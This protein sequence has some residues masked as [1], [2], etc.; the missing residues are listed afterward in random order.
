MVWVLGDLKLITG[1]FMG[2]WVQLMSVGPPQ[3]NSWVWGIFWGFFRGLRGGFCHFHDLIYIVLVIN[4][5]TVMLLIIFILIYCSFLN[6]LSIY[7]CIKWEG[8]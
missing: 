7:L 5:M 8:F 4:A 2:F 3:G 6:H 1:S